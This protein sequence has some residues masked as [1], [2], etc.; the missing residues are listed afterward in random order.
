MR[1]FLSR[2]TASGENAL[3]TDIGLLVLR[4]GAGLA[5]AFAHGLGKIPPSE[6]FV[7]NTAGLGFP[8]P[9]LFA[10]L[11][12]LSEFGGGLLIALGLFTRLGA[13]GLLFTMGVA[14]FLAH[15]GDPFG[16]RE[17]SFVYGVASLALLA[18]GPG[19]FSLDAL[20]SRRLRPASL[21]A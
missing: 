21:Y 5:M 2:L 8:A 16:D 14:F 18:A 17:L 15:G 20:I 12:A 6:G 4:V 1:S 10:W 11:A 19:R 3:A 9:E 7:A 13:A